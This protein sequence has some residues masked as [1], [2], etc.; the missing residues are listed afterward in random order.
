[1][2]EGVVVAGTVDRLLVTPT[3]VLVVDFK[4]GRRVP[5]DAAAAPEHH[6]RQT[7]AYVAALEVVFP[8]REVEAALLYT[9]G[10][11]LLPLPPALVA[12]HKPGLTATEQI[13][14][15]GA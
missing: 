4:T 12:A 3:R 6:L 8:D 2:V 15:P 1:M 11:R 5:A 7:A 13:L 14:P 10:P 9:A